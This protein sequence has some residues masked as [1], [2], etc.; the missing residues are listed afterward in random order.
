MAPSLNTMHF[1][2]VRSHVVFFTPSSYKLFYP[3]RPPPASSCS[4]SLPASPSPSDFLL[5][6]LLSPSFCPFPYSILFLI[7]NFFFF[8][9]LLFSS[10]S[11][12]SFSFLLP[13]CASADFPL[14]SC[15]SLYLFSFLFIVFLYRILIF[16]FTFSS[17]ILSSS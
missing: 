5:N 16:V 10:L 12:F 2:A 7:D 15:S 9:L 1:K 14:S 4:S 6:P 11:S 8:S 3:S 13:S 17:P